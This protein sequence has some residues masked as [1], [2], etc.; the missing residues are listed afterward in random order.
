MELFDSGSLAIAGIP[1]LLLL[2]FIGISIFFLINQ[3]K[4]LQAI[5][6]ENCLMPPSNV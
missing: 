5:S 3:Q 4:T 1:L 2:I 6:T